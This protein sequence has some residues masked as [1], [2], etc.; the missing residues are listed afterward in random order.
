MTNMKWKI[1]GRYQFFLQYIL[2]LFIF[3]ACLKNDFSKEYTSFSRLTDP[4]EYSY[5]LD[6]LPDKVIGICQIAEQQTVHRNL[7]PYFGISKRKWPEMS[8]IWPGG[9]PIPAMPYMLEALKKTDPYNL[10]DQRPVENRLIG[11]CMVES[12]FLTSL[13]RSKSIPARIRAGYFKDTM[14]NSD[15]VISFWE[16]NVRERGIREDLMKEDP[17]EWKK[18]MNDITRREQIEV[19][20][21][22]EHWVCEYWDKNENKWRLLDANI[23]FLKASSDIEVEYHLPPKHFQFAYD[24]WKIMRTSEN[25]NPDQYTEYPH[26]GRSHI[27]SQLLLDYYC[28][29]NHDMAGFD[30]QS[31]QITK[32]V[33][34]KKYEDLSPEE[35]VEMDALADMLAQN[36]S[37]KKLKKFYHSSRTLQIE[38][39]VKDPYS[40]VFKK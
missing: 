38:S 32:F 22:I 34:R 23:T 17:Q 6:R 2:I 3:L 9:E 19:N 27:R 7:L 40:F 30:N 21:H 14:A 12:T 11:A 10:Y 24:A 20:K 36:P 26:D 31:G 15:H 29:L 37:L 39:A 28:L 35:L 5:M 1:F 8:N 18:L 25:F 16:N 13:L 4:K 33:K